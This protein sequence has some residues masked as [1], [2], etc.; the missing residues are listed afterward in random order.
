MS[1]KRIAGKETTQYTLDQYANALS[2]GSEAEKR[3][4]I[5]ELVLDI[6]TDPSNPTLYIANIDGNL[7]QIQGGN[8]GGVSQIIAGN[9]ITLTPST[10]TGIVTINATGGANVEAIP[11]IYFTAPITG[12]NQTFSNAELLKYVS[13]AN[14]TLF[15]NGSLLENEFY[16]LT[17]DTLTVTTLIQAGDS[18]DLPIQYIVS[19]GGAAGNPGGNN[20]SLQYN[21]NGVF[22]GV[23]TAGYDGNRL[24]LGSNANVSVTGGNSGQFLRTDGLGNLSWAAGGSGGNLLVIARTGNVEIPVT[25]GILTVIGRTGN[26]PV[27][28]G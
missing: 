2:T 8:G 20:T 14:I 18:I 19:N 4:N 26:I 23:P 21:Q 11:A 15:L 9:N 25:G 24:I 28:V 3:M 7:N 27:V 1:I 10:G 6:G 5:G 13:N 12:N 22:G 16:T 17:G